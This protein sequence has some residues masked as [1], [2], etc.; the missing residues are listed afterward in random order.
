MDTVN[1]KRRLRNNQAPR[2]G[3][4]FAKAILDSVD[5]RP[6]IAALEARRKP[7]RHHG[8]NGVPELALFRAHLLQFL[9]R[10]RYA[11]AFV[12][13]LNASPSLMELC[14]LEVTL[15]EATY[16]RFKSRLKEH[17]ALLEPII[18][19]VTTQIRQEFEK[20]KKTEALSESAPPIGH[21]L[22][23]DSTDIDAYGRQPPLS[24]PE[25]ASDPDA[26]SGYRTKKGN[27]SKIEK[28]EH[29]YGYKEHTIV[30]ALYG[31]PLA[32]ITQPANKSDVNC[33]MPLVRLVFKLHPWISPK[34][35]MADKAYDSL[36]HHQALYD[37]DIIPI[38]PLRKPSN[39]TLHGGIYTEE[40]FPT[41]VGGIPMEYIE[42]DPSKGHRF[43][44]NPEGC[45]LKDHPALFARCVTDIWDPPE[46]LALRTVG[47]IP[48]FTQEWKQL[49]K[50]RTIVERYFG[51]AKHSRLLNKHQCLGSAKVSLHARMA[52][53]AY[54]ATVA[55]RLKA[56]DFNR[57]LHMTVRLPKSTP[58]VP[59]TTI[60][61][62]ILHIYLMQLMNQFLKHMAQLDP[63]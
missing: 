19:Q 6:V 50:M 32:S 22:A 10:E 42:S 34:Y 43:R 1:T 58:A 11:N 15:T 39:T 30:D 53:L 25:K 21:Y 17:Q 62:T 4:T 23:I 41:C 33:L 2:S 61:P 40:G 28:M 54:V 60:P 63:V 49:Y 59:D 45:K 48:R 31:I 55:A 51:S 14:G 27:S 57:R 38:V 52:R 16:S 26:A 36:K 8:R 29:F 24:K 46:G 56:G 18:A 5:A 20:L 13:A 3:I 7:G 37:L 47:I 35:L 44:C 9:F 12:A